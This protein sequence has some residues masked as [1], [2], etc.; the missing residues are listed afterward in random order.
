MYMVLK[1]DTPKFPNSSNMRIP[2][3]Q[4]H[5]LLRKLLDFYQRHEKRRNALETW[6]QRKLL[7]H[8]YLTTYAHL[9][10][11]KW[12]HRIYKSSRW[13]DN[14]HLYQEKERKRETCL[15]ERKIFVVLKGECFL[16]ISLPMLCFLH[17]YT[18]K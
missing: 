5:Y 18:W 2:A 7:S 8:N 1:H 12:P 17:R 6:K 10:E 14:N 11:S 13:N 15:T 3:S 16:M 4:A 9:L